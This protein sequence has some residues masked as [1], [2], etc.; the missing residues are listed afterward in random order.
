MIS[1]TLQSRI[2]YTE[3]FSF[4]FD[5]EKPKLYRQAK[6]ERIQHYQTSFIIDAKRTSVGGKEKAK[7]RNKKITKW[8]SSQIRQTYNKGRKY[9]S[10][11]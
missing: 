4:R 2:L 7:T 10:H 6:T 1:K 3:R 8:E 9:F 11:I 5:G